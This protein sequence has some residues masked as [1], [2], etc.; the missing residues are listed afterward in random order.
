MSASTQLPA[1][2]LASRA[3]QTVIRFLLPY[4]S[5][6]CD[7][8]VTASAEI[9][10]TLAS[11]GPRNRAELIA[12]AQVIACSLTA[13]ST[14]AEAEGADMSPAVR[15]RFR[16]CANTVTRHGHQAQK[17]LDKRLA[18]DLPQ[19]F[20][21]ADADAEAEVIEQLRQTQQLVEGCKKRLAEDN[22][23][24]AWRTLPA[25]LDLDA[26]PWD[27]EMPTAAARAAMPPGV[28]PAA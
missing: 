11:Y 16:S 27:S 15:L 12:A 19:E 26:P 14:M 24:A 7:D 5:V 20:G 23:E 13:L 3:L 28:P 2:L 22:S 21:P 25:Q 6:D 4:F 17:T 1:S 8:Y 18:C 9:L 10:Q